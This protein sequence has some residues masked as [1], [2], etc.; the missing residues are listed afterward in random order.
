[1]ICTKC[2]FITDDDSVFC[3]RCGEKMAYSAEGREAVA[4][5]FK[6]F[7]NTVPENGIKLAADVS[8]PQSKTA[9]NGSRSDH[10]SIAGLPPISTNAYVKDPNKIKHN[11]E[12]EKR[13]ASGNTLDIIKALTGKI[14]KSVKDDTDRISDVYKD[15]AEQKLSRSIRKSI[16]ADHAH[17]QKEITAYKNALRQLEQRLA[18]FKGQNTLFSQ[19]LDKLWNKLD[20][21][22]ASYD[23]K[24]NDLLEYSKRGSLGSSESAYGMQFVSEWK[25]DIDSIISQIRLS[26]IK[27]ADMLLS[28]DYDTT[29]F[30]KSLKNTNAAELKKYQKSVIKSYNSSRFNAA[31]IKCMLLVI[32]GL[33]LSYYFFKTIKRDTSIEVHIIGSILLGSWALGF[34]HIYHFESFNDSINFSLSLI[35]ETWYFII[36]PPIWGIMCFGGLFSVMCCTI[37][38]F[39][40]GP[41]YMVLDPIRF[42]LGKQCISQDQ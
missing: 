22:M 36:F 39:F 19:N 24:V 27:M 26:E 1:M 14:I 38:G 11:S 12:S 34:Y 31:N 5:L 42:L 4:R 29:L 18:E 13:I 2:R 16:R 3:P 25:T 33:V 41:I 23:S 37:F 28:C 21:L 10:T 35:K 20:E 30:L 8:S 6:S 9:D 40:T 7:N 15:A 17:T 32:A